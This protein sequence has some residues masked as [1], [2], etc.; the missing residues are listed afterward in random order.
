[1]TGDDSELADAHYDLLRAVNR[2]E[3]LLSDAAAGEDL[4]LLRAVAMRLPHHR[5]APPL[6][7]RLQSYDPERFHR[8]LELAG[9]NNSAELIAQLTEDLSSARNT[10]D[11]AAG[12]RDWPALRGAS[13]ILISLT[14]SV[15]ALSLQDMSERL[16]AATHVE[17]GSLLPTLVPSL[18]AELDIL[19]TIIAVTPPQAGGAA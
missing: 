18:L 6:P 15:G 19:L 2:L 5:S 9:P 13:H 14:G 17:D 10:V 12:A 16:N 8:L 3:S 11:H 4:A 7:Q 1:M